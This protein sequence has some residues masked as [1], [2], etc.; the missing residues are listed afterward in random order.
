MGLSDVV[1]APPQ[2]EQ[3]A[4]DPRFPEPLGGQHCR[5]AWPSERQTTASLGT[6]LSQRTTQSQRRL[7]WDLT[8]ERPVDRARP[9]AAEK[10]YITSRVSGSSLGTAPNHPGTQS[11]PKAVPVSAATWQ[12]PTPR[13][14]PRP[15]RVPK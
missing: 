7:D 1:A 2:G 9:E 10:R 15:R 13:S 14:G 5:C 12:S 4:S 11:R 6:E 8:H 3:Y